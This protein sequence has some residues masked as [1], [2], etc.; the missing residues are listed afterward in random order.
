VGGLFGQ[1]G[2][3]NFLVH[4]RSHPLTVSY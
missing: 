4:G 1:H 3:D 2:E